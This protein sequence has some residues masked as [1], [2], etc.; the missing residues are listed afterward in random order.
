VFSQS[1]FKLVKNID[2]RLWGFC[3]VCK[4]SFTTTFREP[5]WVPSSMVIERKW[6]AE[7]HAAHIGVEWV[8]A[9][10]AGQWRRLLGEPLIYALW[11]LKMGPTAAPETSSENLTYTPCKNPHNRKSV[12]IL[13]SKPKIKIVKNIFYL[14]LV[15][16]SHTCCPSKL[17]QNLVTINRFLLVYLS[18]R[19]GGWS[20][21][22]LFD[23]L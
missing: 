5:L 8:W 10:S 7:W 22:N 21:L 1:L 17:V 11:P 18:R 9:E 16:Q 2:F 6:A 4:I 3:T 15:F 13:R 20:R 14:S 19:W 12:F 23:W